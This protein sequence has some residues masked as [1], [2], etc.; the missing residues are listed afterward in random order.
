MIAFLATIATFID[1]AWDL[2][3]TL[4]NFQCIHGA[5]SG[6]N[7]ATSLFRMLESMSLVDK[8][9][10]RTDCRREKRLILPYDRQCLE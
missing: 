6:A 1:K 3:E 9:S 8:V 4:V 2:H 10:N 7:M 5:H